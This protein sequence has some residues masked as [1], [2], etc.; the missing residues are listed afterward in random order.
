MIGRQEQIL[1]HEAVS[2]ASG[3]LGTGGSAVTFASKSFPWA[4]EPSFVV[5][6]KLGAAVTGTTPGLI[7]ALQGSTDGGAFATIGSA[8]ASLST[9]IS[10]SVLITTANLT[11]AFVA[12]SSTVPPFTSNYRMRVLVTAGN[13]DNVA[14]D[15]SIDVV[16]F[17]A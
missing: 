1:S 3:A 10:Q 14:P 11:S 5:M 16:A 7:V 2:G 9:A 15:V 17:S 12:L 6:T 13:A 8:G 4:G